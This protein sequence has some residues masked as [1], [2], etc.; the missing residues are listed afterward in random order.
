MKTLLASGL[1]C[2]SMVL[3]SQA[4]V[5]ITNYSGGPYTSGLTI[6]N[7]ALEPGSVDYAAVGVTIGANALDF[8]SLEAIFDN[9]AFLFTRDV[10]G[11]I[12]SDIGG[13]PGTE[14]AAFDSFTLPAQDPD[15][16]LANDVNIYLTTVF[17]LQANTTYW[18]V[19]S[20]PFGVGLLPNWQQD[21]N[22]TAPVGFG[23]GTPVGYRFSGDSQT[24]WVSSSIN[25]QVYISVADDFPINVE[26]PEPSSF[27]LAGTGL[28]LAVGAVRRRR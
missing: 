10:T 27:V 1:L 12:Y 15:P 4:A 16:A 11:G 14:L 7:G 21:T 19:L 3:P 23:L 13:N 9:N 5:L 17:Q 8:V 2:L 18:F 26:T 20:G 28:L 25:N 6:G 22:N 24:T